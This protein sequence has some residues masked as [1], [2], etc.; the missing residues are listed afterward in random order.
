MRSRSS[1]RIM[2]DLGSAVL[3]RASRLGNQDFTQLQSGAVDPA[4]DGANRQ[5]QDR[6]DLLVLESLDVPQDQNG[7]VLRGQ[8]GERRVQ[9]GLIFL[10]FEGVT[11][12][13]VERFVE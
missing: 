7:P 6:G 4:S 8:A 12:L 3:P 5:A 9:P 10:P 2:L 11:R 13:M 1:W